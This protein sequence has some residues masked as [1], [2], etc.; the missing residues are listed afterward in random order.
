M[1]EV[2]HPVYEMGIHKMRY[3]SLYNSHG[4]LTISMST[5]DLRQVFLSAWECTIVTEI[6][7]SQADCNVHDDTKCP[8]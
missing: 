7:F 6:E 5:K 8:T 1:H 4:A 2:R 3:A